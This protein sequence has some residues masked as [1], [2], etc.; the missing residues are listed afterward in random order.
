MDK[1]ALKLV[2]MGTPAFSAE[3]LAGLLKSG[4]NI[5]A[6][7]TEPDA[8]VGRK[9]IVTPPPVKILAGERGIPVFQPENRDEL[10]VMSHELGPDL[11]VIAAYGRILRKDVLDIPKYGCINFHASLL[12]KYR[13]ASPVQAAII[14]GDRETGVTIMKIDEGMDTGPILSQVTFP[15]TEEDTTPTVLAKMVERGLPLLVKTIEGYVDGKIEPQEQ[16][17]DE[18]TT[19]S[20]IKKED[21]H[22]SFG[23]AVEEYAKYR[24][25]IEWPGSFVFLDQSLPKV[26]GKRLKILEAQLSRDRFSDAQPGEVYLAD[27]GELALSFHTGFWLIKKLQLE[28]EKPLSA[29]DFLNGHQNIIGTILE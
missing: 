22:I 28:G 9:K 4:F 3:I 2:Y 19:C 17:S 8:E 26:G 23:N 13:G 15:L 5:I 11:V 20:M 21:G 12:P 18:A 6:V 24:A 29:P 14:N 25:Y 10:R 27:G 7:I 16:D 1:K